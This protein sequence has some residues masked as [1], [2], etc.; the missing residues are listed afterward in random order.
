MKLSVIIPCFNAANTIAVQLEALANQ[1]WSE[2]WE[3]IV[4][5]NG[6][7]DESLTIVERYKERLPN[8]RIV[9]ASNRRGT[10]YARN[11]GALTANSESLAFCD[12][13]DKVAPGWVAAMGKALARYEFVASSLEWE[14]LNPAWLLQGLEPQQTGVFMYADFLPA[15]ASWGLGVKR[16]I[17]EAAGGFD[18]SML[19]LQDVDYCWK[20]QLLGVELYPVPDA[21][22]H[23]RFPS[24]LD[25]IYYKTRLGA[26]NW[27]LLYKRYKTLGMTRPALRSSMVEWIYLL[28]RFPQIRHRADR[29]VWVRQFARRIG[30]LQGSFKHRILAF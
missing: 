27:V 21:V 19:R 1:N 22:V 20:I 2:P 14:E 17:H 4:S 23:Y 9:D 10:S 13:D 28:R 5:N 12:A 26:V 11:V 29:A 15:A 18:E 30:R 6:S 3:V 24:R 25:D 8:L 16:S 7:T